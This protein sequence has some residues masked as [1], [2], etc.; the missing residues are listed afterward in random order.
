MKIPMMNLIPLTLGFAVLSTVPCLAG[1]PLICHPIEISGAKSL[2]WKN[3]GGW[4]GSDPS[5]SVARLAEDTLAL[6]APGT[7]VPVRM[8][9]LRRAAIY[10]AKDLKQGAEITTRLTA[11]VL[12]AEAAGKPDATA[13]FDA[14]YW[15]E[16]MRQASFLYR[17]NMVS[18][19]EREQWQ[20][21]TS[22]KGLDGYH[23]VRRAVQLGGKNMDGAL[24]R[25]TEYR[26]ADLK[27]TK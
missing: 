19:A 7:P 18:A 5:Y 2:P 11:R 3:T 13:W 10:S 6:L 4:Q 1:P 8:E 25:M 21:R 16:S 22:P 12:D 20:L 17:Y 9:T 15:V 14:G 26:T 27:D 23:W 24:A